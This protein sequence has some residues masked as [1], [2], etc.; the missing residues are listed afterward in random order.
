LTKITNHDTKFYNKKNKIEQQQKG[1]L[2]GMISKCLKKLMNQKNKNYA[3]K[4]VRYI[5]KNTLLV[6]LFEMQ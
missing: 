5:T 2:Q 1:S 6:I 4:L 3:Q